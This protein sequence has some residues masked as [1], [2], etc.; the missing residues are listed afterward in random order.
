M[1]EINERYGVV[2]ASFYAG[3]A[4]NLL[5][6]AQAVFA[7]HKGDSPLDV[8]DVPGAFEIP[9]ACQK[10]L[11][12]KKYA[13]II[14]LGAVIRGQTPHFDYV[15]GECARAIATLNLRGQAP[16]IFGVLTTDTLRQAEYRADPKRG[17]KGAAAAMAAIK[18]AALQ[19]R[20]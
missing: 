11:A 14:A 8:V 4:Q 7:R 13:A 2:V 9:W 5:A 10:L 15:A 17:D 6:G 12:T 1:T 18:M 20:L 16:I 3:I 19:Q